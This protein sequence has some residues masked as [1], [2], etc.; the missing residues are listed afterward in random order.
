MLLHYLLELGKDHGSC[1]VA[2]LT[3]C[4]INGD[5]KGK[6]TVAFGAGL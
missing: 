6:V 2:A 1:F 5:L 4:G 3:Q